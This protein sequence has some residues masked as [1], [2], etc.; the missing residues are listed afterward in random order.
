M[1]ISEF[2]LELK[3][4]E[5]ESTTFVYPCVG[6]TVAKAFEEIDLAKKLPDVME[7]LLFSVDNSY[8]I[9]VG[10]EDVKT[11]EIYKWARGSR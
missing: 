1:I 7:L 11:V 6:F 4:S 10:F 9:D 3:M 5:F 2:R 8:D